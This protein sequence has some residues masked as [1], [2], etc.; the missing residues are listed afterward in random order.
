MA[1]KP[2]HTLRVPIEDT[3]SVH[4]VRR[5][6]RRLAQAMDFSPSRVEEVVICASEL[7]TNVDKHT[8]G[9][10]IYLQ[11]A[12]GSAAR[13]LE[14]LSV[15][16]GPGV[17]RFERCLTD[18]YTTAGTLGT[19]LGAV[20]RMASRFSVYSQPTGG[21]VVFARFRPEPGPS[22]AEPLDAGALCLPA[23]R[24][25]VS[26]DAYRVLDETAEVATLVVDG[27][28]HGAEAA[29]A[30]QRALS[31][32]DDPAAAPPR[33]MTSVHQRLVGTRGAAAAAARMDLPR[34][35][36]E[37]C[38][39]GNVSAVVVSAEVASYQRLGS[40]PGTLGLNIPTPQSQPF[41]VPSHGLL[42]LHTDGIRARWDLTRY[43]GLLAQPVAVLAAV[44]VR[45]FWRQR[46]D[47]TIVALRPRQVPG[48]D[49]VGEVRAGELPG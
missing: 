47:A 40:R 31:A 39:I 26:G 8:R 7:A 25:E 20:R 13:D 37:F 24:E 28:G 45:D 32:L 49:R 41:T 29:R 38:G 22:G 15:D 6:A 48:G 2:R 10:A 33:L 21:S 18:G 36:G 1:V 27:L 16:D 9:G 19:G 30:S 43:P 46:D 23:V 11:P 14:L 42:L 34:R 3:S 44:L 12:P 35:R 4:P 5:V 17:E